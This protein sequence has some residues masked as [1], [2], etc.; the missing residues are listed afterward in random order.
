MARILILTL[1]KPQSC[2]ALA[3]NNKL[4]ILKEHN[5]PAIV[6]ASEHPH[7]QIIKE[8][9]IEGVSYPLEQE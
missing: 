9:P 4:R 6:D 2:L 7:R 1:I 8:H 5:E 3:I